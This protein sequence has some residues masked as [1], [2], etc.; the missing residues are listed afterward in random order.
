VQLSDGSWSQ[1]ILGLTEFYGNDNDEALPI[2]AER[3][4]LAMFSKSAAPN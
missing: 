3:N 1:K 2:S 4:K